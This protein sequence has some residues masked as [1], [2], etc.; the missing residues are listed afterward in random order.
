MKIGE[1]NLI[2]AN[3][4]LMDKTKELKKDNEILQN[5][6]DKVY[7]YTITRKKRSKL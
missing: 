7:L 5:C 2:D 1:R 4:K 3:I 6:L